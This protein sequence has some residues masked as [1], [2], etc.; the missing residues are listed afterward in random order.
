MRGEWRKSSFSG[1]DQPSCVEVAFKAD[2]RIRD[3][4]NPSGGALCVP[5]PAW[6]PRLLISLLS[7]VDR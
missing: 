1:G 5:A 2:I 7:A 6:D 4:K 3:S